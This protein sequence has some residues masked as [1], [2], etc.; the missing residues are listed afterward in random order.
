MERNNVADFN[1]FFLLNWEI[2]H[3]IYHTYNIDYTSIK[4]CS[5]DMVIRY[6]TILQ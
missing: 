2:D 3:K 4:Q 5:F 1:K 6:V